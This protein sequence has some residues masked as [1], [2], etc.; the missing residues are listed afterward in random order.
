MVVSSRLSQQIAQNKRKQ[1]QKKIMIVVLAIILIAALGT[2]AFFIFAS[3]NKTDDGVSGSGGTTVTTYANKSDEEIQAE[4]DE[5]TKNSRMAISVASEAK[6]E[7][8][9]V[10][11]NVI[12]PESNKFDQ[13]FELK[14][15][16]KVL[17]TSGLIEP[18]TAVEWC[19]V[20]GA[21][22]G[23]AKIVIYAH[24]KGNSEPFGNPQEI[25]IQLT[26]EQIS[27]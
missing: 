25:E 5:Q 7:D 3:L 17:F 23:S 14:Q 6:I 16:D 19:E 12:N 11:V 22:I 15:D 18:N 21:H 8:G 10:R 26:G 27:G 1:T 20:S 4:L 13:S 9:K 24:E 2:A